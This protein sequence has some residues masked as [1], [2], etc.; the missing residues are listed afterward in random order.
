MAKHNQYRVIVEQI[1]E[2]NQAIKTLSFE[3]E[4]REDLFKTIEVIGDHSGIDKDQAPRLTLALRLLGPMMMAER[5]HELFKDFMPHF[6]TFMQNLKSKVKS[7][8]P[9]S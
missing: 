7:A 1:S 2:D 3:Y 5:K 6:K 4:D 8:K 9:A